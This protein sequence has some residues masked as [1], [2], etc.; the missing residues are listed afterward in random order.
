M[1]LSEL[2][3]LLDDMTPEE[4]IGQLLQVNS[5]F[6]HADGILTGPQENQQFSP[7]QLE[8]AGSLLGMAGAESLIRFQDTYMESQPHRIPMIFMA[9]I[10]NGCK[11]VFPI[12]LAQGATFNPEL[13]GECA[14]VAARES[15]AAGLHVTFS[16]MADLV[17][18]ARW[19]RVMESTGED[20]YLNSCF[21]SAVVKGYQ[22]EGV[23]AKGRI[24]ACVKHF[25][26]YG[27]PLAGREY[28]QAEISERTLMEE[29]LP[30]YQAAIEA[31][32]KL[33]MTSFQT[34]GR[35]PCTGNRKL[36]R[37]IL[38]TKM[39]FHG[40]LISDWKATAELIAH[41]VAADGREAAKLAIEAGVDIDMMA[42]IYANELA[43]L[44]TDGEVSRDLL[45]EAVLR[46]LILK[47][48]L[49][50]FEHPYKD[51]DPEAERQLHLCE[52]HR[53]VAYEAAVQSFVLLK[54]DGGNLPLKKSERT[55]FLGPYINDKDIVGSWTLFAEEHHCV[56][57]R[58]GVSRIVQETF[59]AF[60]EGCSLLDADTRFAGFRGLADGKNQPD[61]TAGEDEALK[62]AA[63]SD[64]VVLCLGE[65]RQH[66]G[67]GGA[68]GEITLPQVQ[69]D[70]LKKAAA[71][72]SNITVVIFCGRPL[73]LR[74]VIPY[75]KS[76]LIVWFP[77]S[78]G[79]SA[80]ADVLYGEA[81][82]SGKLS[83]S[84]PY[85]VGQVPVYYSDFS[86]GR[87]YRGQPDIR[88]A[89][90]YIDIPNQPLYPFGYG[91]S[92]GEFVY[93]GLSLDCETLTNEGTVNATVTVLNTGVRGGYETVQLY[94]R[95]M[96][97]SVVRPLRELKGFR[98]IWL[99][100]GASVQVTFAITEEMLRFYDINMR[101]TSEAGAYTVFVG[102]DSTAADSVKFNLI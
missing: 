2:K 86:T 80:I 16:P 40:V 79:G 78:E 3:A 90:K 91:L 69:T 28:N 62:L 44:I 32:V 51:A 47:N 57:I 12:P 24:A 76:I 18:D 100:P 53:R 84:F 68:R 39:K 87:P 35:I 63:D 19:G 71:F 38:R 31:G 56:S 97:A 22:G 67:E 72:N 26:A 8:L 93:S 6:Y 13:A 89:S 52:E 7:R 58:E 41:G 20:V 48:E 25:A 64:K 27:A 9:D 81:C 37:D 77:G 29:Y 46:V 23:S 55:A 66:S 36:M 75:A 17:R 10:I 1:K 4:K 43:A 21:S 85:S 61:F 50:L 33:V 98:K 42:D 70:F 73:D 83:M 101:Y 54:N 15:A 49:G 14:A 99:E 96:A 95:D 11:T 82:P 65:H 60:Q 5:S 102:G 94:L 92:Y 88:F 30:S 59:T 34:L 74:N 45:D